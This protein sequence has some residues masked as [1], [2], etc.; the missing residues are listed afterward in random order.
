M[1]GTM[2]PDTPDTQKDVVLSELIAFL[3]RETPSLEG[4]GQDE[5]K[6]VARAYVFDTLKDNLKK[7]VEIEKIDYQGKK[8]VFIFRHGKRSSQTAR[9]YLECLVHM[10]AWAERAGIHVLEMKAS[11]ADTYIDT[12]EGSPS[13]IRLKIAAASSFF[14]FLERETEG[15]ILNPFRGTKVRPVRK[16]RVPVVPTEEEINLIMEGLTPVNRTAVIVMK[17]V[18]L[19]VGALDSLTIRNGRYIAYSKGKDVSGPFPISTLKAIKQEGLDG[20]QPF[21]DLPY[22]SIRCAFQ[23]RAKKLFK[24][25]RINASYSVHDL[26]HF[27]AIQEYMKDKDIYRLKVLLN[28]ASIQVTENYLKGIEAYWV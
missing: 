10:E 1:V 7:K 19:R 14:T 26:R 28:H 5:L 18:G 9:T 23:Y 6:A 11:Q 2:L 15:R 16:T 12:L 22:D 20:R 3:V 25:G 21:A 13:S 4:L 27:Y 24:E 17:E 8:H